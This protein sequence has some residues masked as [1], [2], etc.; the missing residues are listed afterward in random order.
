MSYQALYRKY[1]PSKLEDVV[2]QSSVVKIVRNAIQYNKINHAY[3]FSGPRGTG[4]TTMAK[5]FAKDVNCLNPIDGEACGTCKN[6]LSIINNECSDII[7]IDAASNNGVDE[8]RE[9]KNKIN[10]VPS[11]LKYKVYIIDEVHMLSI[12]AFNALLKTLE[13]PPEHIIFILATTDLHK[14]PTTVISRCQCFEFQRLTEKEISSRLRYI[15]DQENVQ[16]DDEVLKRI[17]ELVDGG[18]RDAIGMLDKAISYSSDSKVSLTDFEMLNGIVSKSEKK[19]FISMIFEQNI[20]EII[21][22]IDTIYDAGKDLVIFNQDLLTLCRDLVVDY[23]SEKEI[24]FD[25]DFLLDFA[26]SLNETLNEVKQSSNMKTVFEMKILSFIYHHG[27]RS[28]SISEV[29]KNEGKKIVDERKEV[30]VIM[31]SDKDSSE[32]IDRSIKQKKAIELD[33]VEQ[34]P[35]HSF[36]TQEHKVDNI[37]R[38]SNDITEYLKINTIIINNCFAGASK[39]ELLELRNNWSK[40]NDYALDNHYGAVA[41]YIFDG[42]VRAASL[43]SIIITFDYESMV[44]RGYRLL[45]K[46]EELFEIIFGHKIRV[47]LLTSADWEKEKK[48]YIEKKNNGISYQYQ[49]VPLLN[50][51]LSQHSPIID[52]TVE[53]ASSV[54][55][56]IKLF[57]ENMVSID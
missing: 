53:N 28:A 26:E 56:A 35:V 4:K 19:K 55:E 5:I 25:I 1:R 45:P 39:R 43:D 24:E 30:K 7:E 2:G 21:S 48:E 51:Q 14:V 16:V 23:Y 49:E 37:D 40:L 57:G 31:S 3:L 38:V 46:I 8:I 17:A 42:T 47:A 33:K 20:S 15:A 22:F 32:L 27:S 41:C 6:C 9:I 34:E 12:G 54:E 52:N 36:T 10:L 18:M 13:E 29:V 11:E 44:N 50:E